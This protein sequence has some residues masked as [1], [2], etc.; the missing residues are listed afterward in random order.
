MNEFEHFII[1][2]GEADLPFATFGNTDVA[3]AKPDR[4]KRPPKGSGKPIVGKDTSVH[5]KHITQTGKK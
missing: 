4:G 1:I 2:P 5:H 3:F